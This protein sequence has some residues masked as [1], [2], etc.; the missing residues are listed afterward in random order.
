MSDR[1]KSLL[2]QAPKLKTKTS[3]TRYCSCL[4]PSRY[5]DSLVSFHLFPKLPLELRLIIWKLACFQSRS[6]YLSTVPV[7]LDLYASHPYK[8]NRPNQLNC[9]TILQICKEAREEALKHYELINRCVSHEHKIHDQKVYINFDVDHVSLNPWAPNF[10][11]V[12]V[13]YF[14]SMS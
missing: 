13:C 14:P 3:L 2:G 6:V 11:A 7:L 1:F 10:D 8:M 5:A 9:P 12:V 4:L